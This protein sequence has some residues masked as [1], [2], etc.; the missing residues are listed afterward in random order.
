MNK[1]FTTAIGLFMAICSLQAQTPQSVCY[2]GVATDAAG[3]ELQARSINI[4]TT[5][6]SDAPN[7][8]EEWSEIHE[9]Q[10]D[11][12]GL[13]NLNIGQGTFVSGTATNFSAIEWGEHAFFLKVEMDETG[14]TD[15]QL[16]GI[17]Q[18]MSVPYALY[19]KGA[20]QAN[21]AQTA[22]V[23][24]S[25]A[26]AQ[27]AYSALNDE[28]TSPFNEIQTLTFDEG[29]GELTLSGS[30]MVTLPSIIN[31]DEQNANQ[32]EVTN[33]IFN[34]QTVEQ[35]LENIN[36]S[37]IADADTD[38]TNELQ[39]A[40]G[41]DI[42]TGT[43]NGQT[44]T[45]ALESIQTE[46]EIEDGDSD[47]TNEIQNATE[48]EIAG[49]T[50]DG[51]NVQ[52]ALENINFTLATD[53]DNDA[54]NE[55]Q[56]ANQINITGGN[57]SGQTVEEAL[58]NLNNTIATDADMDATNELQNAEGVNITTGSF[59]GQTVA[60]ALESLQTGLEDGDGDSDATNEIQ[61]A[62]EVEIAGGTFDGQNVQQAIENISFGLSTDN[63]SDATNELQNATEIP[64]ITGE[65]A[66]QSVENALNNLQAISTADNDTNAQNEIQTAGEVEV[67]GGDFDGQNVEQALNQLQNQVDSDNDDNP[68]NE[69]QNANQVSVTGGTYN[70]QTVEQ[71]LEG[72]N[73]ELSSVI[74]QITQVINDVAVDGDGDSTNEIQSANEV[75]VTNGTY[76]GQTVEQVL[77]GL[78]LELS[79][80]TT[81]ITQ[82]I[83]DVSADGDGDSMNEIQSANE[84]SVTNGTYNGQTV[85]QV[86]EGLNTELSSVIT[87]ITQVIN[88]VAADGDGDATNEIQSANEVSVT[89]GIYNGQT[90]EQA[91]EDVNTDIIQLENNLAQDNDGD[92]TNEIQTAA[93]V[94][95]DGGIFAGQNVEEILDSLQ[96]RIV[97]DNDGDDTNEIQELLY[98]GETLSITGGN[99]INLN[100]IPFAA[101]GANTSY[102]QGIFGDYIVVI[103]ANY[104]VP[105]GKNFYLTGGPPTVNLLVNGTSYAHPTT[106]SMPLLRGG[107]IIQ[108]CNCLGVLIDENN[109]IET[110]IID[111]Q[112]YNI[113]TV[114]A[115][116]VFIIKSGMVNDN[117]SYI[118]VNG[119]QIEFFRPNYLPSSNVLSFPEGTTLQM[120]NN[121]SEMV[122]TGYLVEIE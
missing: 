43:F 78:S 68:V 107:Q 7:G 100:D 115:G 79:T 112:S 90:V 55:L 3:T 30:N 108:N 118:V 38:A 97:A 109:I 104:Q 73:T 113:Y 28:D 37:L 89:N 35:A 13:F 58:D 105:A 74:T 87:Q 42:T 46:L 26:I 119:V 93:T 114:P 80:V 22:I 14:G 85:E 49:G 29:T 61:N 32:V 71:V 18:M 111:F 47:A 8:T 25:A 98:D 53:G 110:E 66:G 10:T 57:Y 82:V 36:T 20:N 2:Q 81:Q 5:I 106:P 88:D 64:I 27:V 39:N 63:D 67:T 1:I 4:R 12:F 50:F 16:M 52:Q 116:K 51:Q 34:G 17:N 62:T 9:V 15:Y 101:P 76:N 54:T 102:P 33:G 99:T 60:E 56:A 94:N 44:V 95:I 117:V 70:G 69:I 65:F 59:N 11:D 83:N 75:S 84:V 86:L 31:T 48:V 122:L 41:V 24:D 120:P 103:S 23:A 121:V 21:I 96:I 6:L 77:E 72:L 19:S 91:L 45:E 40:E 92:A